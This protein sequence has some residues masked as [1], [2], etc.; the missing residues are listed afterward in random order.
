MSAIRD[1]TSVIGPT[2]VVLT[3]RDGSEVEQVFA[4]RFQAEMFLYLLPYLM[5]TQPDGDEVASAILSPLL[6][7]TNDAG[8]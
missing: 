5:T 6:P 7:L 4:T 8:V 2:S 1:P 3:M